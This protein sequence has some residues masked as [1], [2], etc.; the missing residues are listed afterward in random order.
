[1]LMNLSKITFLQLVNFRLGN[2]FFWLIILA[3]TFGVI[4][5]FTKLRS[6]EGAGASKIGTTSIYILVASIGMKMNLNAIVE[7]L[8]LFAIGLVWMIVHI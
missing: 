8:G 6:Y 7:N 3:T 2:S 1:M 5:S 4:L